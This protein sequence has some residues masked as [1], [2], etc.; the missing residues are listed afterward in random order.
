MAVVYR[1]GPLDVL[2]VLVDIGPTVV[3][4]LVAELFVGGVNQK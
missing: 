4:A 2:V 1:D 3:L